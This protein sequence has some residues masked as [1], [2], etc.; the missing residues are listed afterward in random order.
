[1]TGRLARVDV[2]LDLVRFLGFLD[3]VLAILNGAPP[4]PAPSC[5]WCAYR[6]VSAP[7][8]AA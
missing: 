8:M 6:G 4:A 7:Q 3:G 1:L 2:P 5:H